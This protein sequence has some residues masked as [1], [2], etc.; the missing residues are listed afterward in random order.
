MTILMNMTHA[1]LEKETH[2]GQLSEGFASIFK[3][4]TITDYTRFSF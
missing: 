3:T 1:N 4:E 2:N